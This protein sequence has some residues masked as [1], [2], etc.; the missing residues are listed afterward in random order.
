MLTDGTLL[1]RSPTGVLQRSVP[2]TVHE[3]LLPPPWQ[4]GCHQTFKYLLIHRWKTHNL[5]QFR[6]MLLRLSI[7]SQAYI[8]LF[9]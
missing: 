8:I 7:F 1:N 9:S 3:K 4:Q 5:F 6:A 2:S